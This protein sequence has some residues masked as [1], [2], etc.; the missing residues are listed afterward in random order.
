M[1]VCIC[2]G[3]RESQVKQAI[4]EGSKT[5]DQVQAKTGCGADCGSCIH[6][7]NKM[8]EQESSSNFESTPE[9]TSSSQS[10]H[11]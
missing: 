9:V 5:P 6:R 2:N 1:Y 8:L 10:Q 4:R 11:L 3:I 7:V